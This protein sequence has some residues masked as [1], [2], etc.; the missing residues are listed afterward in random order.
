M[1]EEE[2]KY[3]VV[4]GFALPDL[5]D[6]VPDGGRLVVRPPQKLRAVYYDTDDLRLA[7]AGASLRFRRGDDGI[8]TVMISDGYLGQ[9]KRFSIQQ[10]GDNE[11]TAA[12][13]IKMK[14]I[15]KELVNKTMELENT[16]E[17]KEAADVLRRAEQTVIPKLD[18]AEDRRELEDLCRAVRQAMNSGDK[19]KIEEAYRAL[20][21]KLLNYAYLL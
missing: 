5:S 13:L 21:D 20:D 19:K 16:A 10:T 17:F 18:N 14:E 9:K 7:R 6:C 3:E 8:L 1:L 11:L 12:Q 2:R 4:A 15:N